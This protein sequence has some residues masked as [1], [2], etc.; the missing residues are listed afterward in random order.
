MAK[1]W[2]AV[3]AAIQTRLDELD[4]TQAE[5]AHRAGVA[6]ETVRELRNNLHPR[7]RNPRT[8][9][10]VSEALNWPSDHLAN[11]LRGEQPVSGK[12]ADADELDTIKD[13]LTSIAGRLTD[14][15]G[16]LSNFSD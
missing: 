15:A 5:L 13:E 11:V 16:R 1:D 3:A 2:Q 6:P 10:A 7:R 12:T 14:I 4:I 9:S 8:L